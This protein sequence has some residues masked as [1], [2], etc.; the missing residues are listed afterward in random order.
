M[1]CAR[2]PFQNS[3][4]GHPIFAG[5]RLIGLVPRT[6]AQASKKRLPKEQFL[7]WILLPFRLMRWRNKGVNEAYPSR[8]QA[9]SKE[10]KR[11]GR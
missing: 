4:H 9:E 1:W 2:T 8:R 10:S 11:T 7:R 5:F 3:H 6:G